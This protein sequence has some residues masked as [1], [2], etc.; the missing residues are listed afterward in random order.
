MAMELGKAEGADL[1]IVWAAALLH[2]VQGTT[3]GAKDRTDHHLASA[4]YAEEILSS[5]GWTIDRVRAIQHAIRAHRFRDTGESPQTIE[6]K[7]VFDADKLDVLG[8]IGVARAISYAT[9]AGEPFY[10]E[11]SEHFLISGQLILDEP[12]SAYHEFKFKL[13]HIKDRLY[14]EMAKNYAK[15]RHDFMIAFF[16][17]LKYEMEG[18][19]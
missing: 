16:Q 12:H 8:A 7:V 11:P 4:Q 13:S 10:S 3:P 18:L 19:G 9:L 5:Y 1:E 17:Q 15:Q 6:A 2:D 14:T